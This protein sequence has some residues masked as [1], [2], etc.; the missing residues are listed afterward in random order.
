M[1][2]CVEWLANCMFWLLVN[3]FIILEIKEYTNNDSNIL[4]VP[5]CSFTISTVLAKYPKWEN[6]FIMSCYQYS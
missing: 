1:E 2:F 3:K 6:T 5:V 4:D